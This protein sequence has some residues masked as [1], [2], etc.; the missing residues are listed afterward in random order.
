MLPSGW[1]RKLRL[2]SR[3]WCLRYN[4]RAEPSRA[5][6]SRAEPSR[7]EP[8][9]AEPSRAEPSRA[10]PS[11]AEPSRAEPSRAEPSR[12]EPSRAEPS[13]AEPSRAEPTPPD[14]AAGACPDSFSESSVY[15]GR[16]DTSRRSASPLHKLGSFAACARAGGGVAIHRPRRDFATPATA[17]T[18]PDD[19]G[20]GADI[21][22]T[23]CTAEGHGCDGVRPSDRVSAAVPDV[24]S[25]PVTASFEANGPGWRRQ[26]PRRRRLRYRAVRGGRGHDFRCSWRRESLRSAIR[27]QSNPVGF[28][29]YERRSDRRSMAATLRWPARNSRSVERCLVLCKCVQ[30]QRV[31]K[32]HG[33]Q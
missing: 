29:A 15:T 13:R 4:C 21:V 14:S 22:V 25:S 18:P 9:R 20:E 7:A 17:R 2:T 10:E 1:G 11:R 3:R 33:E 31:H 8:S 30:H 32:E 12:A 28:H 26:H 5:E 6:P 19:A 23:D 24:T 27:T 16:R